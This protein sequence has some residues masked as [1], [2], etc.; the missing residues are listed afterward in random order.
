MDILESKFRKGRLTPSELE[1]LRQHVNKQTDLDI[2]HTMYQAWMDYDFNITDVDNECISSIWQRILSRI[3]HP[4]ITTAMKCIVGL[5][6]ASII[7]LIGF[8]IYYHSE[9]QRIKKEQIITYTRMGERAT[10]ILPDGTEVILYNNSKLIHTI[11][12]YN[13]SERHIEFSGIG[14]FA[15]TKDNHRPFLID[16]YGLKVK[17]T[18]TK[19]MLKSCKNREYGELLLAQ[20]SVELESDLTHQKVKVKPGQRALL[21]YRT[22]LFQVMSNADTENIDSWQSGMLS[23]TQKTLSIVLSTTEDYYGVKI[24]LED[25]SLLS[26]RFT[27]T[28]PT[29]DL[30]QSLRIIS[31]AYGLRFVINGQNVTLQKKHK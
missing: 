30:S 5:A 26:D 29:N 23:F 8:S 13:E 27:G 4:N 9:L 7:L 3:A 19:F 28:L 2:E 6:A 22:G 18:G 1:V 31:E 20:G 25:S 14:Y 15:V 16:T 11:G 10:T 12:D 24:I 17:V 21:E